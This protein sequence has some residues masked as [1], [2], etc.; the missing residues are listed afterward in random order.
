MQE[1]K[2][3]TCKKNYVLF[4]PHMNIIVFWPRF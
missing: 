1:Y 3:I 2:Q 4:F